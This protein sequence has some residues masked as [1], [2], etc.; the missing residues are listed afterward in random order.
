MLSGKSKWFMVLALCV[1][2]LA[3]V[4]GC[5]KS[6]SQ[7]GDQGQSQGA[8]QGNVKGSLTAVGSTALQPLVEQAATDFM[9]KNSGAQITVQ[10]GGSGTG[11]SQVSQGAVQIGDSDIFAEQGKNIDASAITDHKVCVIGFAAIANPNVTVDN[12]TNQQLI[13]IFTGKVTNWKDVGG[14]DQPIVVINRPEGSGTRATFEQYALNNTPASTGKGLQQDSSGTILKAVSQTPGAISYLA[15]SYVDKT[16]KALKIN[17]V[18]PTVA[19]IETGKYNVWSYEHMYTKGEAT[20]L[21]KAFLD[22]MMTNDVQ[23]TLVPKLGYIPITE[24]KVTKS[25]K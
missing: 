15:L 20:G 16:V 13:D 3:A 6:S 9:G 1:A 8:Q 25:A 17:G 12:L 24:M 23:S 11:L 7:S 18:D 22:Y 2:L 10:G 14:Q 5:G 19:N 21:T 4:V